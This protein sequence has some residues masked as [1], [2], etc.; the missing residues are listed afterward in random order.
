MSYLKNKPDL[1]LKEI[2]KMDPNFGV[3]FANLHQVL[4]RNKSPFSIGERELMGA[5]ISLLNQCEFCYTEHEAIAHSFGVSPTLLTELKEDIDQSSLKPTLKPI[6]KF[7]KKINITSFK[8]TPKD[9]EEI[10]LEGWDDLAIINA[11]S[12]CGL[13]NFN[14]ILINSLGIKPHTKEKLKSTVERLHNSGYDSTA[15]FIKE[16]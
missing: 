1:D 6:F 9:L 4:L 3:L 2:L 15:N 7:L 16:N 14:N 10:Y 13:F 11:V 8:T 5:Y 12:I